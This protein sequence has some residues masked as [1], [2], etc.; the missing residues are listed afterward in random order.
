MSKEV[1][2]ALRALES[3]LDA[4]RVSG[5]V[6]LFDE[7][8]GAEFQTTSPVGAVNE[9]EQMLADVR[10]GNLKVRSSESTDITVQSYGTTA[11]VRGK[12]NLKAAFQGHDISGVY[13]Y[14]HLYMFR[15]GRWQ[16]VAAHTSRRMPDWV[17]L[18]L[19]RLLNVLH[20]TRK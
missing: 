12:A 10:S 7:V 3:R 18:I 17:F 2:E 13:A 11:I 6:A 15:D 19:T 20:L 9:R 8:L 4:A 5:D 1:E 14:T 16:V